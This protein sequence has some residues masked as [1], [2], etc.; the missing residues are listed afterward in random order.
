VETL[1]ATPPPVAQEGLPKIRGYMPL[2]A[3]LRALQYRNFRLF[4]G[5][6][7]ISLIGTWMQ[8]VGQ[9]WLVYRLTGSSVLLGMGMSPFGSLAAGAAAAKIGAPGAVAAGGCCCL[10]AAGAF[11]LRLP[12]FRAAAGQLIAQPQAAMERA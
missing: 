7:F 1:F 8:N 3:T 6:Q 10:A 2:P 4:F 12:R 5:G 11:W 9:A